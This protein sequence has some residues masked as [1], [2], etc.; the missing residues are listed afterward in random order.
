MLG[1]GRQGQLG[2][3]STVNVG[4]A[5]HTVVMMSRC[6]WVD[7]RVD[8]VK[9]RSQSR[10]DKIRRCCGIVAISGVAE[11]ERSPQ[12]MQARGNHVTTSNG[13]AK[14]RSNE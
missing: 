8:M 11:P 9:V 3:V 1:V 13:G 14:F 2:Q 5:H 12:A 10:L 7:G 4:D 6:C